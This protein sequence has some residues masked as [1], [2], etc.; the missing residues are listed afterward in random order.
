MIS[1]GRPD[2]PDQAMTARIRQAPLRRKARKPEP[3]LVRIDDGADRRA[4]DG[5]VGRHERAMDADDEVEVAVRQPVTDALG[6]TS[7]SIDRMLAR[8]PALR[9]PLLP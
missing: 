8:D 2:A 1:R 5:A 9:R 3:E 7:R 6:V 4:R